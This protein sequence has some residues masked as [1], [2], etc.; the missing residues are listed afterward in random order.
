VHE[1][2][3][4]PVAWASARLAAAG[5]ESA[6]FE[7]QLLVGLAVGVSRTAVIAGLYPPLDDGAWNRFRGLVE[8][9]CA[10]TPLAYL[11]GT[12]E[13]YGLELEVGPAVLIPRPETELLVD[14]ARERLRGGPTASGAAPA[15]FA[16]VGT[17]SG[18]IAVSV[19]VSCAG[20][21]CVALD[22]SAEALLVARRNAARHSVTDRIRLV[23]GDLLAGMPA[24]RFD[25]I[26]SNPPYIATG[27]LAG[28]QPEVR[29]AEPRLALD[30][31]PDGLAC[32][33]RLAPLALRCLRPGG[34][35][36]VEVALGQ[37]GDVA[38]LFAGAGFCEIELRNDAAGI[39]RVVA[40]RSPG[41]H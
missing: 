7:A 1:D 30:G 15:A 2:S 5:V 38:G 41:G 37:A 21:R 14:F 33:K 22:L 24:G 25:V 40:A 20:T 32:L 28:L 10:R 3:A 8:A 18:C 23:R 12:Q 16:D 19:L 34:W 31:G 4:D 6:R 26:L 27:D 13:F 17:G 39:E 35:L 29:D 11:R 9:R 36:A